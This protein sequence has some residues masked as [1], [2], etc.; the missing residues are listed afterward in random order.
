[1]AAKKGLGELLVRKKII[2]LV[3][4]D[5]A[6]KEQKTHGGRL[7]SALVNLGYVND[8]NLADFLGQQYQVPSVDLDNFDIDAEAL[9]FVSRD[10]CSKYCIIPVS[11]A[12]NTLVVAFAD[13]NNLFVKDDLQILTRCK[14]ET[15][16][17]VESSINAAIEKYFES[18]ASAGFGSIV[19]EMEEDRDITSIT[20]PDSLIDLQDVSAQEAPIVRFVSMMLSEAI[21]A[22]AS[23]IHM[24]PYEKRFRVRFRVDGILVEKVQPPPGSAS[25]VSNCVKIMSKMDITERRRPQDGR[26]RVRTR[27]GS[28]ID[29]RVSVLPTL[30]GEK[31][32]LRLLDKSNLQVDMTKLGFEVDD[33]EIYK[34]AIYQPQGMILITGPTGSGKTTTI[35]SA[36][37]ELNKTDVNISTAE[38]PVEFNL[39]GIN[40]VQVNPDIDFG[41]SEALKTF[42]RQDPD[43]V[44]V[45]EIRDLKTAEV[46]FKA[47]ATGHLVVSTLHTNDAS[48]TVVRLLD[49]GVPPFLVSATITLIV[50]QRLLG[51]ICP[52][53]KA[54]DNIKSEDLVE[55]GITENEIGTFQCYVGEGCSKCNNTGIRGRIAVFEM[56]R[57]TPKIR[58]A[59]HNHSSPFEIH[60]AAI[61]DGMR[62][63]RAAAIIKLKQGLVCVEEVLTN[64]I[65]G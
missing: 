59:V 18:D 32:V 3:Q 65:K 43:I 53:C 29:F 7:S 61:R 23:D 55:L 19:T 22:R 2:N 51:V 8:K 47:A 60:K 6:K 41:F 36:L 38:D 16:V 52:N 40:Q 24:E 44:M 1:M 5:H 64:T 62:V 54:K 50:A 37:N 27:S 35:Y 30:F 46:A 31:V 49:L 17:A 14:I 12:G 28:E 56:M 13:P 4:L 58:E 9:K 45:G 34:K 42:L 39:D 20:S 15:V 57:M 25:A 10:I 11:K 63:L 48:S 33:L 21:K 26:L